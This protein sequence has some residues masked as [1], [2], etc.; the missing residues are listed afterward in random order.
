MIDIAAIRA[1]FTA[2]VPFLEERTR[3]L[4]AASEAR[5]AG[6]GG[7]TAASSATGVARGTIGRGLAELEA[8]RDEPSGRIRRPGAGRKPATE[9]QPGLMTALQ[10]LVVSAIRGDPQG[11]RMRFRTLPLV[12]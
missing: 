8:G 10:D 12:E 6:R 11:S 4:L 2:M 3:R 1:R 5:T 7:I 9:T